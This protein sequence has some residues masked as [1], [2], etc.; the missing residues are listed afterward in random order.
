MKTDIN[1]IKSSPSKRMLFILSLLLFIVTLAALS[2][3]LPLHQRRSLGM[4]YE[5][6]G[7]LLLDK[8]GYSHVFTNQKGYS[9]DM[10]ERI[11]IMNRVAS[12]REEVRKILC[13]IDKSFPK[14]IDISSIEISDNLINITGMAPN[15]E[16]VA[17]SVLNLH[18]NEIVLD[19]KICEIAL[20][21]ETQ[22]KTFVLKCQIIPTDY[23]TEGRD[24]GIQKGMEIS[25]GN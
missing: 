9:L 17:K 13:I 23:Y 5:S 8:E 3:F 15:N 7:Q 12:K 18:D 4:E 10:E 19:A 2:I 6:I 16:G 22:K 14:E 1:F 11:E 24:D 25:S 21:R 20:D